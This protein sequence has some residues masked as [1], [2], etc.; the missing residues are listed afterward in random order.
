MNTLSPEL[1]KTILETSENLAGSRLNYNT[2]RLYSHH[3]KLREG[4]TGLPSWKTSETQGRLREAEQLLEAGLLLLELKQVQSKQYLRRAAELF[5]WIDSLPDNKSYGIPYVFFAASSYQLAGYPARALGVLNSKKFDKDY[6]KSLAHFLRGNF[7]E[8]QESILKGLIQIE[9]QSKD[10]DY[11]QVQLSFKLAET[12]LRCFGIFCAWLRWGDEARLENAFQELNI[13]SKAMI[14]GQ[15]SYSWLLSKLI[16]HISKIYISTSLRNMILPLGKNLTDQGANIIQRYIMQTFFTNR[17]LTWPSQA[18]GINQLISGKSFALCTPT[19]SGK[20][21][22]A[23]LAILQSLFSDIFSGPNEQSKIVLYLVPSR[24]L[25]AEVENTISRVLKD[26]YV[27]HVTVTSMYG[28]NDWG[29]SDALIDLDHSC[30]IIST[31]EKAEALIRFLGTKFIQR[32]CCL[33]LDEAHTVAFDNNHEALKESKSRALHLEMLVS[34]LFSFFDR[35]RVRIVAL[36]AVSSEIETNLAQWISGKG[37]A[38]AIS[39]PYRSTR[40]LVGRLECRNNGATRIIYDLLDGQI[41]HIKG[42]KDEDRPYIPEPFPKHPPVKDA[43]ASNASDEVKMR[44]HL[45][46]SAMHLASKRD[47]SDSFHPVLISVTANPGYFAKTFIELLEKDWNYTDL[48]VFFIKPGNPINKKKYEDCLIICADYFG[49]KSREYRLLEHGIVLHHGK[50]PQAMSGLLV[51]LVRNNIINIVL[52]TSTLSEGVNLPVETVLIPSLVRH[53]DVLSLK[54]FSN[55][56]GRAGRPGNTTEGRSLVL[57]KPRSNG[58]NIRKSQQQYVEIIK[59]LSSTSGQDIQRDTTTDGALSALLSYIFEKW[60]EL[61]NSEDIS[62]FISWL[63]TAQGFSDDALLALDSLDGLLMPAIHEFEEIGGDHIDTEV[64]LTNLWK[65]TF[66]NYATGQDADWMMAFKTRGNALVKNIYP[67]KSVRTAI[68]NTSLPPRDGTLILQQIDDFITLFQ[69]GID[70]VGWDRKQ[71]F[72]YLLRLI[73]AVRAIPSFAFSNEKNITIKELLAWWLWP[74]NNISKRPKPASISKW[75]NL[76]AKKFNYLFNWG[77]GSLIGTVLNQDNQTGTTLERWEK[78]GL[79]WAV[80]WIKDLIS[81][82]VYDPVEAFLLN[83]RK[84]LTRQEAYQTAKDYWTQ[85]DI[86][87]GDNLLDPRK[88]KKWFDTASYKET[89]PSLSDDDFIISIKP[90]A[91]IKALA[92]RMWRVLPVVIGDSVKWYDVAGYLLAT[93]TIPKKWDVLNNVRFNY[94]L[95]THK[96]TLI[97]SKDTVNE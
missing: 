34:R 85:V 96:N 47:A 65:Q 81:W 10:N 37:D 55:L 56:I 6:S 80:I 87:E 75:Y 16:T 35:G 61:T 41:L 42:A 90:F 97:V 15:D 68:Y 50:M 62:E 21:R 71:R 74:N 48:P 20:T 94:F 89:D 82:G 86:N 17:A 33:V 12:V 44:A 2:A 91:D 67:Q 58:Y 40:Q 25:A 88:I 52:A 9:E 1:I 24:A 92:T 69:D 79:P 4:L 63:E 93:S 49:K 3:T 77:I 73:D 8:L 54:E 53:P 30:V 84:A 95:D 7:L 57:V 32:I 18:E 23:E 38:K 13:V 22:I 46:W 27:N 83:Q 19:G 28:G 51:Q 31:H 45:L 78:A 43:I 29:P 76:G 39:A 66:S 72:S 11:E 70:Y 5:E 59:K 64:Y 14:H 60:S 36:S 26:I